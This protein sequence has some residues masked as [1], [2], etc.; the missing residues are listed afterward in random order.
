MKYLSLLLI[1]TILSCTRT[2]GL[3]ETLN[4]KF[5]NVNAHIESDLKK[6]RMELEQV[7]IDAFFAERDINR[8]D[9]AYKANL[10]LLNEV[11]SKQ[12]LDN[13]KSDVESFIKGDIDYNPY[14]MELLDSY[15]QLSGLEIQKQDFK[16]SLSMVI[17]YLLAQI[18]FRIGANQISFD[19]IRVILEIN[20]GQIKLGEPNYRKGSFRGHVVKNW[21]VL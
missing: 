17:R 21:R 15:K 12:D 2:N 16:L 10:N 7:S 9:S 19:D 20:D 4:Q 14:G 1:T 8:I 18:S 3:I 5:E 6:Y 13:L 11:G